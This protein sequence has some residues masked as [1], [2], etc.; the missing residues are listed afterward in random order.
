MIASGVER[1]LA[2]ASAERSRFVY[3]VLTEER[4]TDL[5]EVQFVTTTVTALPPELLPDRK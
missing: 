3:E 2:I 1:I 4:S 5:N